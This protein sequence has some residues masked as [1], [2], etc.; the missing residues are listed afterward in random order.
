MKQET[1]SLENITCRWRGNGLPS[2]RNL[3]IPKNLVIQVIITYANLAHRM[4][5]SFQLPLTTGVIE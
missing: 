2:G 4:T 5:G 3:S 1:T